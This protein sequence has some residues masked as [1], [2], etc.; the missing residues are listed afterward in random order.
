LIGV[1][2]WVLLSLK[3]Y[4]PINVEIQD[5]AHEDFDI[6]ERDNRLAIFVTTDLSP[7]VGE[8][9]LVFV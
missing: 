5:S 4:N 8:K 2:S 6:L 1:N 3:I 7:D 9:G